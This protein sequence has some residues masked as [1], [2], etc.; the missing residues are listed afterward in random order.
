M[1]DAH[2]DPT[3]DSF[4]TGLAPEDLD[5]ERPPPFDTPW[6]HFSLY[7][8]DGRVVCAESFCPHLLGP[9]FQGTLSGKVMTCPWHQW[10]FS[11]ESGECTWAPTEEARASS[12]IAFLDVTVEGGTFVLRPRQ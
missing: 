7:T 12:R 10:Q 1:P 8:V 11:L 5:P 4:D 2:A 9:L 3:P 6:G